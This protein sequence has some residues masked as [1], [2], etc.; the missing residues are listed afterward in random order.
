MVGRDRR[1]GEVAARDLLRPLRLLRPRLRR[2]FGANHLF[3][4]PVV[5]PFLMGHADMH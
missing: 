2:R 3:F 4:P 1:V 5:Y